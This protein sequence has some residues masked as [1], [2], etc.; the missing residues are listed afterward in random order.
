MKTGNWIMH[1]GKGRKVVRGKAEVPDFVTVRVPAEKCLEL[2][3]MLLRA[4][5]AGALKPMTVDLLFA[6][7]LSRIE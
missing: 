3:E 1:E 2:A 6:G 7:K 4:H 5:N